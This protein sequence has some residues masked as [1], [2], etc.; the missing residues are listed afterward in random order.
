MTSGEY[1]EHA[2]SHPTVDDLP[3]DIRDLLESYSGVK[4]EDV[5]GHIVNVV[6]FMSSR[7]FFFLCL[8][9][10]PTLRVLYRARREGSCG[11]GDRM[12]DSRRLRVCVKE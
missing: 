6:C 9:F 12:S 2:P 3:D 10:L 8:V 5:I 1:N 4:T 11:L 7:V